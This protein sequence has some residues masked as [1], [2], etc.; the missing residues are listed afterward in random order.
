MTGNF[1]ISL[2]YRRVSRTVT[3]MA[4]ALSY[5]PAIIRRPI[6]SNG[7]W[8]SRDCNARNRP[9]VEDF[10]P[11]KH[12]RGVNQLVNARARLAGKG[13]NSIRRGLI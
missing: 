10:R 2:H 8:L 13:I 11:F 1:P 9:F 6:K 7:G 3:L 12:P 4:A 5:Q